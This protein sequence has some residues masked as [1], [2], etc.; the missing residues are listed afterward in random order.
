MSSSSTSLTSAAPSATAER[1]AGAPIAALVAAA[2]ALCGV[3]AGVFPIFESDLF[4]HLAAGRWMFEHGEIPRTDPFRFTSGG[5]PWVDHEWLFQLVVRGVETIAGLDGLILLRAGAL[6]GFTLL[7]F[8]H[9]RRAGLG[10]GLAGILALAGML[11]VRPRFLVRPEIVTLFALLTLV[12]L[13]DRLVSRRGRSTTPAISMRKTK[14]VRLKGRPPEGSLEVGAAVEDAASGGV[15]DGTARRRRG[16]RAELVGLVL[17]VGLW[18]NFHGQALLAPGVAFLFLAGSALEARRQASSGRVPASLLVGIPALLA[19]TLVVNPYGW[20]LIGVPLGIARALGGLS[21]HNPEWMSSF[22]APQP[23]LYGALAVVG[24]LATAARLASGSWPAPAWGLPAAAMAVLALS[25]VRHQALFFAL[26]TPFAAR[27]LAAIP[28]ARPGSPR[29]ER[30]LALATVLA[31]VLVALWAAAP[32]ASGLLRPRHGGLAWGTGLA[33]GRFPE[34]MATVIAANPGI[35]PLYNEFVHGGYL[36][37]RLFPPRQVFLDGRMEIE[38]GLLG[39]LAAARRDPWRWES[40]LAGRGAV[41]ALV[42][43]ETRRMP[44]VEPDGA[45]GLRQVGEST[46]NALL[47]P[48]D[49]WDLVEWDD[50]AM[51]FLLRARGAGGWSGEPYRFVQPEDLATTLA[52]AAA[53]PAFRAG[54]RAELDRKLAADPASRR[55]RYLRDHL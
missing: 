24:A 21:A 49:R 47:F 15:Q 1:R 26:A 31:A 28:D 50:E 13:L 43:Y 17:L 42:R 27:C 18:V 3:V 40:F 16:S 12:L 10:A 23:Y 19:A 39:E 5:A 9:A 35:G 14:D 29:R 48:S 55:A 36:L 8:H 41:G 38:P 44:V 25:G 53:D 34:R 45:G 32:P 46:A 54:L 51:L 11:G 37:W 33:P 30:A 20:R 6:G 2:V 22:A 4:W 7:L 52:R